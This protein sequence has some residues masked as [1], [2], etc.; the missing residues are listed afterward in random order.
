MRRHNLRNIDLNLLVA[1]EALLEEKSVTRAGNRLFLSQSAMSRALARL[2]EILDDPLLVQS[3]RMSVLTPRAQGLQPEL[4]RILGAI[5]KF[6]A[7]QD[8][9]PATA[10]GS[11]TISATDGMIASFL[12]ETIRKFVI[13]APHVRFSLREPQSNDPELLRQGQID[14]LL[15]ARRPQADLHFTE[16]LIDNRLSCLVSK[17]HPLAGRKLTKASFLQHGHIELGTPTGRLIESRLEEKGYRRSLVLKASSLISAA[18]IT[19]QTDWIFTV[20]TVFALTAVKMFDLAMLDMPFKLV[21]PGASPIA[22]FMVWHER[23]N[24]DPLNS[25]VRGVLIRQLEGWRYL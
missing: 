14:L 4:Q 21:D 19:A 10:E 6:V 12:A 17:G 5:R 11:M 24:A 23:C 20:P 2:R 22:L 3:G 9:D 1:L 18:A 15:L 13:E 16:L 7:P 8:F 25:W